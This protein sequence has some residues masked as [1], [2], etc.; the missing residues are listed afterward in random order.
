M[1]R[2]CIP[3]SNGVYLWEKWDLCP[4]SLLLA[5][6]IVCSLDILRGKKFFWLSR[7]HSLL[8]KFLPF[9]TIVPNT[10]KQ[11]IASVLDNAVIRVQVSQADS[12]N[13][14]VERYVLN[15]ITID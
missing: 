9:D 8:P 10:P 3:R 7:V 14:V 5:E 6:L 12:I 11:T 1:N 4:I 15:I 2:D 13:I